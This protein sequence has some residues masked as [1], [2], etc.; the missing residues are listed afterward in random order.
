MNKDLPIYDIIL[1]DEKQGVAM[2]SLVDDPA[3]KVNWIALSATSSYAEEINVYGFK[4]QHFDMCPNA[5]RLFKHLVEMN[6]DD[7]TK[8]MVRSAAGIADAVFRIEKDAIDRGQSTNEQLAEATILVDD[9]KDLILEINKIVNMDHKVDFMDGHIE[10]IKSLLTKA[11]SMSATRLRKV[12]MLMAVIGPRGGVKESKKAPKSSTP[13]PNP[14]GRGTAPGSAATTRGAK[15]SAEVEASL[16]K[17]VDEF[18]DKY[19]EKLGFGVNIGMLK[20]VYQRGIGAFA[21][22]HSPA[23]K[24]ANQWAQAR[25]NAFLYIVKNGRPENPKYTR[26]NDLLPG[27]HKKKGEAGKEEKKEEEK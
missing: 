25:V 26:D 16:Q 7:E 6:V 4:P 9:F 20:S 5:T 3:I 13:N 10:K 17:K 24:S 19:K 27:K 14:K 8:G 18:N 1:S 22:S 11:N 21:T 2:I 12:N 23:V 15:V